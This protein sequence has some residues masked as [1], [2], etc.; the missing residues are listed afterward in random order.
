MTS[1]EEWVDKLPQLG[2]VWVVGLEHAGLGLGDFIWMVN[3]NS[4]L[5][6]TSEMG[7]TES[8]PETSA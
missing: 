4:A 6:E 2:V 3:R 8:I 7:R 1:L 5:N